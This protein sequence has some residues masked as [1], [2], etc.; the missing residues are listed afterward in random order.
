MSSSAHNTH[1]E[2]PVAR[3]MPPAAAS[4]P[5]GDVDTD[6][7]SASV[8]PLDELLANYNFICQPEMRLKFKQE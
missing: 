2:P 4:G 8:D 3:H 1:P 6:A 5:G 7:A